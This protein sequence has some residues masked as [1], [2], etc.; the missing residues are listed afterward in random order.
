MMKNNVKKA[1][2]NIDVLLEKR[3]DL[4]IQLVNVVKGYMKFERGILTQITDLRT[5]WQNI[6]NDQTQN[7]MNASN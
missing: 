4:I 6:R 3:Y 5:A 2:A 7:K 1:W